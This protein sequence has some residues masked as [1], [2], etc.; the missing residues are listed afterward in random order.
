MVTCRVHCSHKWHSK[1]NYLYCKV[2]L[3]DFRNQKWNFKLKISLGT[4]CK[5]LLKMTMVNLVNRDTGETAWSY[6]LP[7][8]IAWFEEMQAWVTVWAG[9]HSGKPAPSAAFGKQHSEINVNRIHKNLQYYTGKGTEQK[10]KKHIKTFNKFKYSNLNFLNVQLITKRNQHEYKSLENHKLNINNENE[11]F[12]NLSHH[13][14]IDNYQYKRLLRATY[15]S[16][17]VTCLHFL[18]DCTKDDMTNRIYKQ[19]WNIDNS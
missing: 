4:P 12:L 9:I 8:V 19:K 13:H 6:F 14:W 1:W 10:L 15:L 18:Y 2:I 3:K 5:P 7:D 11:I 17:N 16:C